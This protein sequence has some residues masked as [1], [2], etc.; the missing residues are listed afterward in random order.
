MAQTE[1]RLFQKPSS[2]TPK[3]PPTPLGTRRVN[4]PVGTLESD[5][6]ARQIVKE[7]VADFAKVPKAQVTVNQQPSGGFVA[8]LPAVE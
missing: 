2:K 3:E 5:D 1:V 4:L 6:A 8:Y 7:A